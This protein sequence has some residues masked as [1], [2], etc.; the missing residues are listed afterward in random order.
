MDGETCR[1]QSPVRMAGPPAHAHSWMPAGPRGSE[2]PVPSQG[3]APVAAR[4]CRPVQLSGVDAVPW[5]RDPLAVKPSFSWKRLGKR[6]RQRVKHVT[7]D[8]KKIQSLTSPAQ[9]VCVNR[10][11]TIRGILETQEHCSPK[12][13][14]LPTENGV[15]CSWPLNFSPLEMYIGASRGLHDVR[16]HSRQRAEVLVGT[17][18]T[19][20]EQDVPASGPE[21]ATE[22]TLDSWLNEGLDGLFHVWA[23][24]LNGTLS[25]VR[26]FR[27]ASLDTGVQSRK[28]DPEGLCSA[29]VI[30][31]Y[32]AETG[33]QA[34]AQRFQ[35]SS[36]PAEA[37]NRHLPGGGSSGFSSI[38]YYQILNGELAEQLRT[39][40]ALYPSYE[41][42][43]TVEKRIKDFI[44]SLFIVLESEHLERATNNFGDKIPLLCIPFEKRDLVGLDTDSSV[45]MLVTQ[46][47]ACI[48]AVLPCPH[49]LEAE[50]EP[51]EFLQNVVYNHLRQIPPFSLLLLSISLPPL[52]P[53]FLPPPIFSLPCCPSFSRRTQRIAGPPTHAQSVPAGR[54]FGSSSSQPGI[55]HKTFSALSPGRPLAPALGRGLWLWK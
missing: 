3:S 34:G 40:V 17:R 35:G 54:W 1:T 21:P 6:E 5:G 38:G 46:L 51:S 23:Q 43:G 9:L 13:L 32:P 49:H 24:S 39:D 7:V 37:A 4:L 47:E 33:C 10:S 12:D 14:L 30:C 29:C 28:A 25:I 42:C 31:H 26:F 8:F 50:P 27:V 18:L 19:C 44:E 20:V 48:Q 36:L 45:R 15:L 55:G 52:F 16:H 22:H 53:S 11:S 41:D 2:A